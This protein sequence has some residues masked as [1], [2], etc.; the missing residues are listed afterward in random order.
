MFDFSTHLQADHSSPFHLCFALKR[1]YYCLQN[2]FTPLLETIIVVLQ[3]SFQK[4]VHII[5]FIVRHEE[6]WLATALSWQERRLST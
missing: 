5:C 6:R 1:T 4:E 3:N 2:A